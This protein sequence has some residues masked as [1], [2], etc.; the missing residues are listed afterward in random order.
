MADI[1]PRPSTLTRHKDTQPFI[2]PSKFTGKLKG[3]V[4][5]LQE[6]RVELVEVKMLFPW[7]TQLLTR[8]SATAL[9]LA[10]AGASIACLARTAS[11]LEALE[12]E[13]KQHFGS[14]YLIHDPR[15]SLRRRGSIGSN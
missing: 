8:S 7:T 15:C 5:Y 6:L 4:F 10:A 3:K 13:V 12:A 2:S 14:S 9:A 1:Y 11:D